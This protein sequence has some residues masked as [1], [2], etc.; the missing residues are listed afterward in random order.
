[1]GL[2]SGS[3]RGTASRI[4]SLARKSPLCP[5]QARNG[6]RTIGLLLAPHQIGGL[7]IRGGQLCREI[8]FAHNPRTFLQ[9][10]VERHRTIVIDCLRRVGS[11]GLQCS[12]GPGAFGGGLSMKLK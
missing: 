12:L 6:L 9:A 5:F 11:A 3:G 4:P 8:V 2:R 1:M 10:F 7:P